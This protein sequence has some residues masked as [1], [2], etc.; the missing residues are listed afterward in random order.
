MRTKD[1][2]YNIKKA[3]LILET[4]YLWG[5]KIKTLSENHIKYVL[6]IQLPENESYYGNPELIKKIIEEQLLFENIFKQIA[7]YAKDKAEKTISTV[8]NWIDV[9]AVITKILKDNT[10][11]LLE[12]FL[13]AL[14]TRFDAAVKKVIEALKKIGE[15][16]NA[17]IKA[18]ELVVSK[19]ES[20][21]GW[22]KMFAYMAIGAISVFITTKLIQLGIKQVTSMI[23]E[24]FSE[25]F[26]GDL[27][28][29]L[30]GW[31]TFI[32][33]INTIKDL[34]DG[35]WDFIGELIKGFG[36]AMKGD[37]WNTK[38]LLFKE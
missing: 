31:Q 27:I 26:L 1:K 22:K 37:D 30:A 28:K 16:G 21:E 19:I 20:L 34:A 15:I 33:F 24:Y 5:E 18:I 7:D 12:R 14:K 23:Q 13:A 8:K 29:T 6:G 10:G 38:T 9:A 2:L 4:N 11:V 3:N 32:T 25:K 36:D 35:L 17:L